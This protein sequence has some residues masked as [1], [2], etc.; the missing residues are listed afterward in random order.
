MC[1]NVFVNR[2]ASRKTIQMNLELTRCKIFRST[3]KSLFF[4]VFYQ[5]SKI[6]H[7]EY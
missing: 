2:T 6:R 3:K 5:T 7:N 4:V 1:Q